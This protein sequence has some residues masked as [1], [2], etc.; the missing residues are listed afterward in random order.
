MSPYLNW[1]FL[2]SA[3][4]HV[5]PFIAKHPEI[6]PDFIERNILNCDESLA[7][8]NAKLIDVDT[9]GIIWV[10]NHMRGTS[11]DST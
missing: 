1:R 4:K 8:L 9:G 5:I 3:I 7:V 6:E 11:D 2:F 10:G